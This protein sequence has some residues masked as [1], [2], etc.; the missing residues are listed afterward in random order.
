MFSTDKE[1]LAHTQAPKRGILSTSELS[2]LNVKLKTQKCFTGTFLVD[3]ETIVRTLCTVSERLK[4]GFLAGSLIY[5]AML[6][7]TWTT[8]CLLL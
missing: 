5:S 3:K 6:L 7:S 1:T 4:G 8:P 2:F